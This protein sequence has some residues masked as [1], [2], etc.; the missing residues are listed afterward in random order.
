MAA[1]D[2]LRRGLYAGLS[3][4]QRTLVDHTV[5]RSR[6][7][8]LRDI[9]RRVRGAPARLLAGRLRALLAALDLPVPADDG[10]LAEATEAAL[11]EADASVVW[12]ALAVLTGRL[13]LD[14]EV[15]A[16]VRRLRLDGPG[17]ALAPAVASLTGSL[18]YDRWRPPKLEVVRRAV[19]VD[20]HHT[21]RTDLATGIQRVARQMAARWDRDH[22]LVLVGWSSD[23]ESFRRLDGAAR[24]RALGL[25]EGGRRS[26]ASIAS[27]QHDTTVVVPWECTYVMPELATE[28][29][30]TARMLALARHSGNRTCA[31]GFDCVPLTTAETADDAMSG[32]FARLLAAVRHM[33]TVATISEAAGAEYRGWREMVASVG[34]HGPAIVPIP[35][36]T[37]AHE[38]GADAREAARSR[39]SV[40]SLPLVLCVGSH[41]PRKNHLAVL[42][43]AD[44]L[45]RRGLRFALLFVGGNAWKCERFQER[46]AAL[47]RQR[48]F[49]ESVSSLDDDLLW[50]AYQ[51]AHVV[52]FPS[53]NEG[54]GL[55][56][57][58]A[59]A[60][61]T[62]VITSR[63]GSMAEVAGQGGALLVDPR[64]DH[65][66]AG[67]L[68][69]VLE[70]PVLHA[71][72]SADARRRPARTWD[73]YAADLWQQFVGADADPRARATAGLAAGPVRLR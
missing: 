70:D 9:V 50:A 6:G 65:D 19:V 46:V 67:A 47:K 69:R 64:D 21:S 61:G 62:P 41:E 11:A 55:P 24:R 27:A 29:G 10:D 16:A 8:S 26:A 3:I 48:R 72:L 73:E 23:D 56:I 35:L 4:G 40:G 54:F 68:E 43:A 32:A 31:I 51:L 7:H 25:D 28:P 66:L 45:W 1:P 52:V 36:P 5:A 59:L 12:L 20:L 58:E 33:D 34:L 13:P 44:L 18:G 14:D 38:P 60:C 30:R 15:V 2:L 17:A 39:F 49:V 53:I 37:E 71:R 57:A 63:H 22:E 42:H